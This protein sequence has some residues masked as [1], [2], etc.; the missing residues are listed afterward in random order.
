MVIDIPIN[1][2]GEEYGTSQVGLDDRAEAPQLLLQARRLLT[3]THG[4]RA[5]RS[6]S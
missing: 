5:L 4:P 6:P 1:Q 2:Q 3:A